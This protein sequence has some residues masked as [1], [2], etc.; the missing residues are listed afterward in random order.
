MGELFSMKT[1]DLGSFNLNLES[2]RYKVEV[3]YHHDGREPV[4][5]IEINAGNECFFNVE[6]YRGFDI[7]DFQYKN[8]KISYLAP[9]GVQHPNVFTYAPGNFQKHMFYGLLTTCG[10]ENTGPDSCSQKS[11][12]F[13]SQHGSLNYSAAKDID[14]KTDDETIYLRAKI[15]GN[16]YYK[17]Q[18]VLERTISYSIIDRSLKINDT[19]KNVGMDKEQVCLMYHFNFGSPFL[20]PDCKITI[21]YKSAAPK[22]EYAQTR[23]EELLT[24]CP[25]SDEERPHVFYLEFP[26][27]EYHKIQL[28]NMQLHLRLNIISKSDNLPFVDIW[29]CFQKKQYVMAVEPCNA[30]PYGRHEQRR[31]KTAEIIASGKTKNYYTEILVEEL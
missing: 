10:L 28:E 17:Q 1:A 14:I 13:V 8:V 31:R 22:D 29:K 3:K 4:P 19:V 26:K 6:P 5:F 7:S 20:S 21:P 18:L 16:Q 9:C 15:E 27:E 12:E 23:I 24:V 30:F 2:D 25:S 11:N